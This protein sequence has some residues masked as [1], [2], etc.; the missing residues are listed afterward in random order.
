MNTASHL[1]G[2]TTPPMDF[3]F[4]FL[5][6][7]GR[8]APRPF[9]RGLVVLTGAY[10]IITLLSV[11]VWPGL[12]P[13]QFVLVFPYFCLFAKRLHDAGLS[14]WLWLAFLFGFGLVN[15]VSTS[16]LFPVLSPQAYAMQEEVQALMFDVLKGGST[17]EELETSVARMQLFSRLSAVTSIAALLITSALVGLAAFRMRSEPKPNRHGPP[18]LGPAAPHS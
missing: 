16:A 14:A 15:L 13:M 18:T 7:H 6:P 9:A 5:E 2:M 3:R 4:L 8:L 1:Q 12:G 10:M 11:V 17:P